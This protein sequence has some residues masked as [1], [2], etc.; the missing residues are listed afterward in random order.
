MGKSKLPKGK[1]KGT[2]ER[3]KEFSEQTV[4]RVA[5][6]VA[7][8]HAVERRHYQKAGEAT[9]AL[10]R[11]GVTVK[12]KRSQWNCEEAPSHRDKLIPLVGMAHRL[13][14]TAKWLRAEA[15]AGRIP[16]LRA[17]RALLFD[18]ETV[19]RI[20]LEHARDVAGATRRILEQIPTS[21]DIR[22]ELNSLKARAGELRSLLR[23]AQTRELCRKVH[24]EREKV[25]TPLPDVP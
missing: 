1:A 20:L 3:K 13:R 18:P 24:T 7:L 25:A 11:L 17:D 21:K 19:Q 9:A 8:A 22:V 12:F 23:V 15:E 14:V 10:E 5:W 16:H 4:Q 6:F 2:Q